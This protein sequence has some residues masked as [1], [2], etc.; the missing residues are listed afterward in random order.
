MFKHLS[1][2]LQPENYF[3]AFQLQGL[4]FLIFLF[5]LLIFCEWWKRLQP[6]NLKLFKDNKG[7]EHQKRRTMLQRTSC[8]QAWSP[9][10]AIDLSPFPSELLLVACTMCLHLHTLS[11][12]PGQLRY[13][14]SLDSPNQQKGIRS[15]VHVL[16][17]NICVWIYR[18]QM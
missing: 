2:K 14:P 3:L 5:Y 7:L 9:W 1:L 18:S 8:M 11:H 6:I 10:E 15:Q 4:C 12:P 17:H 13:Q 16:L